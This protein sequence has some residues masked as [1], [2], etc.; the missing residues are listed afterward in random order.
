[1][2]AARSRATPASESSGS[3]L[4]GRAKGSVLDSE[5]DASSLGRHEAPNQERRVGAILRRAVS[6]SLLDPAAMPSR[7]RL[8]RGLLFVTAVGLAGCDG[9][10]GDVREWTAADH[11]QPDRATAQTSARAPSTASPD[12]AD[13]DLVELSWQRSCTRCHGPSGRGD[14]PESAMVRAPD[15]TR[16]EWQ[17]AVTDDQIASVIRGGRNKMPAFDLPD[18]VVKGLVARIRARRAR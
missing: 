16:P 3:A 7:A 12:S 17:D 1:M 15:L 10:S 18:S 6:I 14:G 4:S 8:H 9:P 11:D 5:V 2:R 13:K